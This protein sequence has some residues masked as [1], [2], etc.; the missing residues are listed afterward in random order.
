MLNVEVYRGDRVEGELST[1]KIKSVLGL[2]SN[3]E[4]EDF[5]RTVIKD[6][7]HITARM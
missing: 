1:D 4:P 2:Q 7:N 3:H 6:Y 5:L